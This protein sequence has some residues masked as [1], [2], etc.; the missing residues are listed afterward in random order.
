MSQVPRLAIT[1]GLSSIFKAKRILLMA[2]GSHKSKIVRRSVEGH[3]TDQVP[4]SLLQQHS[5]CKFVIDEQAAAEL[6]RFNEPWLAGDWRM[7]T[8]SDPQSSNQP[9]AEAEQAYPDAHR[10]G[11]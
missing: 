8:R 7:D 1:M 9:G 11:L 2:W 10:Q 4:A 3:S 6:T 5:N